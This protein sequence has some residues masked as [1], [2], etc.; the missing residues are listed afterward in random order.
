VFCNFERS[1][2]HPD[3]PQFGDEDKYVIHIKDLDG[4]FLNDEEIQ[5]QIIMYDKKEDK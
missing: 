5:N 2:N 3:L 1:L 4:A